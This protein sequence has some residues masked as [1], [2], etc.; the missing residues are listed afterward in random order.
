ML[1]KSFT[2]PNYFD[3]LE[4]QYSTIRYIYSSLHMDQLPILVKD[5]QLFFL[6]LQRQNTRHFQKLPNKQFIYKCYSLNYTFYLHLRY[7]CIHQINQLNLILL[8]LTFQQHMI[9]ISTK[10]CA[11]FFLLKI[12]YFKQGLSTSKQIITLNKNRFLDEKSL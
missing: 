1:F 5:N 2:N 7:Q 4:T 12:L 6:I 11:Q 9:F 10:I 8:K 3:C